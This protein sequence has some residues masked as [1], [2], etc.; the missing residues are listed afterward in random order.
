MKLQVILDHKTGI[1][2]SSNKHGLNGI[3]EKYFNERHIK[4]TPARF[5]GRCSSYF[6]FRK[7]QLYFLEDEL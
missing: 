6:Q 4:E 5:G 3:A 1:L 2:K 7:I